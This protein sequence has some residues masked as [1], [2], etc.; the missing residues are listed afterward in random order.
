MKR[1]AILVIAFA[2]A[3]LPASAAAQSPEGDDEGFIMRVDGD[4]VI[5]ADERVNTVVVVNGDLT[6]QGTVTDFV[7]VIEGNALVSG[8]VDG[9]LTVIS[10]DIELTSTAVV[11]NVNSVRGDFVRAQGATV[12]GDIHERDNFRFFWGI[13]GLFSILFWLAVT[14]AMI[15]AALVF[16]HFGARQLTN[17]ATTMTGDLV[18]AI[19]GTVVLWVGGPLLAFLAFITFIGIPVGIG[20][21]VFLLPA[22][23]FLGYLV[24][25]TRLGTFLLG[26][27]G[28]EQ[29]GPP[30]LAA[31]LGVLLLQLLVLVPVFGALAALLAGAWGAGALAFNIYRGAGGKG[32]EAPTSPATPAAEVP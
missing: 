20:I 32:F 13:A 2:L 18:N 6:L 16:A 23:G 12:T 9:D 3:A 11:D 26:L 28:R 4:V 17:A 1:L 27:G 29:T 24:A 10:G 19:I 25:G 5:G 8:T 7:L 21:L 30:Y 22:L 31:A 14:V 15:V